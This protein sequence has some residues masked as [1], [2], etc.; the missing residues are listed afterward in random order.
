MGSSRARAIAVAF[1]RLFERRCRVC[2]R[3]VVTVDPVADTVFDA[4]TNAVL[5][6]AKRLD[7]CEVILEL[8]PLSDLP[9]TRIGRPRRTLR[10]P[11]WSGLG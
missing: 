6:A 3:F 11:I 2:R 8:L 4:I 1:F 9:D 7:V 10:F 5:Y